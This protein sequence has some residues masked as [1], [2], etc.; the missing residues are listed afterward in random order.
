MPEGR[1]LRAAIQMTSTVK[2]D[3][4][5]EARIIVQQEIADR[6]R[7]EREEA[8]RREHVMATSLQRFRDEATAAVTSDF[9]ES[10]E[11]TW[12]HDG[13]RPFVRFLI[14]NDEWTVRAVNRRGASEPCYT[15]M[16]PVANT[17][18]VLASQL[19]HRLLSDIGHRLHY[20][21]TRSLDEEE[22]GQDGDGDDGDDG[23]EYIVIRDEDIPF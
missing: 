15:I 5:T 17:F 14:D 2:R 8:E 22:D 4:R 12:H 20:L 1:G 11:A 13:N 7:R 16:S 3:I 9:W 6:E 23:D 18:D 10:L 19:E 21:A